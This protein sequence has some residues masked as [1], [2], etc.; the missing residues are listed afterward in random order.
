MLPIALHHGLFGYDEL[1][2][3][4]LRHAYWRGVDRAIRSRGHSVIITRASATGTVQQR[5]RDLKESL[6]RHLAQYDRGTRVILIGHSMGG[7]DARYAVSRLGLADRVA[8]VITV[9]T[10]H[11]G[12]PFADWG[13]RNLDQRFGVLRIINRLGIEVG[14]FQDLTTTSCAAFNEQ[15]P[16]HPDVKYFSVSC[17]RPW[18]KMPPWA[19]HS[20]K[21]IEAAEG[22]NDGLVSIKSAT[23]GTH[24]GTWPADHWHSMNRRWLPEFGA[25]RTGDI[26]PYY[27]RM[28]DAI[29]TALD[30]R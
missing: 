5:A 23:W 9:T 7:L 28:L 21:V 4:P 16:D 6:L 10:P 14:A 18:H 12:S 1:R 24:L 25:D 11:R 17:A 8:A 22:E 3:G 26:V 27:H 15:T 20:F 2:L 30:V 19:M 13:I 29:E